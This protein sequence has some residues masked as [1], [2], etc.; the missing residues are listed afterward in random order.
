MSQNPSL[1]DYPAAHG[2]SLEPDPNATTLLV[3]LRRFIIL[4]CQSHASAGQLYA[5]A[6]WSTQQAAYC[7]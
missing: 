7:F 6:A 3:G 5:W 2:I 1:V 4:S